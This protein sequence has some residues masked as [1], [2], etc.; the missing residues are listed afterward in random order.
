MFG[1][2]KE[3]VFLNPSI[4]HISVINTHILQITIFHLGMLIDGATFHPS[5]GI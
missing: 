5:Y 3:D 4:V 2:P 1:T